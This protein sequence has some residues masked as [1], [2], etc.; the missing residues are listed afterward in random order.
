MSTYFATYPILKQ[1][2]AHTLVNIDFEVL[3]QIKNTD[4]FVEWPLFFQRFY[5][6]ADERNLKKAATLVNLLDEQLNECK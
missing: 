2:W 4:I 5:K 1:S 3:Y 6:T